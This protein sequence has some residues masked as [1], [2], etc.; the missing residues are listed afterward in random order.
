MAAS[1]SLAGDGP[2]GV[3]G[4]GARRPARPAQYRHFC[5]KSQWLARFVQPP[6]RLGGAA[7]TLDR[8]VFLGKR[9][10]ITSLEFFS[11]QRRDTGPR[12]A[13]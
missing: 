13:A 11:S 1:F 10:K 12:D 8:S 9:R 5:V 6:S 2:T 4:G 3:V 7:V